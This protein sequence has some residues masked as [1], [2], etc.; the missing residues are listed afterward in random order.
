MKYSEQ[1]EG[2]IDGCNVRLVLDADRTPWQEL[3][4]GTL[5]F[6]GG[7]RQQTL[8]V[9]VG[10]EVYPDQ[11]TKGQELL[12]HRRWN[13]IRVEPGEAVRACFELRVPW[14]IPFRPMQVQ[15]VVRS[16]WLRRAVL[17]AT[18][19][20][21]PPRAFQRLAVLVE[22]TSESRVTNWHSSSLGDGVSAEL[23]PREPA[24]NQIQRLG[25]ELFKN[26]GMVYGNLSVEPVGSTLVDRLRSAVGSH[27]VTLPFRF[28]EEDTEGPRIFFAQALRPYIDGLRELPIPAARQCPSPNELPLPAH[29]HLRGK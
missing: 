18:V 24:A 19:G 25:L 20:I 23:I 6:Q 28:S 2:T 4:T 26:N 3:V 16:G 10:L 17:S 13:A 11:L 9:D 12:P 5:F 1:L 21:T 14:G 15:A 29:E 27:P 7:P 22:E 8:Q